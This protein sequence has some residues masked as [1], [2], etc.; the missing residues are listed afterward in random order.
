MFEAF[1][2]GRPS[3]MRWG[4]FCVYVRENT[5]PGEFV[6]LQDAGDFPKD[7]SVPGQIDREAIG[8]LLPSC[9]G[10][11][12]CAFTHH[13]VLFGKISDSA[14]LSNR[15]VIQACNKVGLTVNLS[16]NDLEHADRLADLGIAPVVAVVPE[17]F[18]ATG[19]KTPDG[20]PV[21]VCLHQ[22]GKVKDCK[23]CGLCAVPTRKAIVGLRLHNVGKANFSFQK[24]CASQ[25]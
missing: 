25:A 2:A 22:V 4:D 3:V 7:P 15:A 12:A 13:E 18:P 6:R 20:R 21:I 10:R 19:G 5:E 14:V 23:S 16:G 17:D 9:V 11:K 8:Q 24:A 1:L